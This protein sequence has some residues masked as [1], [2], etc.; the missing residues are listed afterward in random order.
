MKKVFR[1]SL[2]ML[3]FAVIFPIT[4]FLAGCGATPKKEAL[5]VF[6]ESDI[7]DDET[8]YAIFEV[9]EDVVTKLDYKIN[10]STWAGYVITYAVKEC[11]PQNRS[12]FTLDD[13]KIKVEQPEFEEIKIEI[14]VNNHMDTCIVRLKKYPTSMFLVDESGE[15][16]K[17]LDVTINAFGSYTINPYGRFLDANGNSYVQPL[18][19][20]EYGFSLSCSDETVLN[21]PNSSRLKVYSI[22]AAAE[23]AK[24]TVSLKDS[25]GKPLHTV[26]VNIHVVLNAGNAFATI[27]GYDSFVNDSSEIEIDANRLNV[28]EKGNYVLKYDLFIMS[29]DGRYI[30]STLVDN[31]CT[32]SDTKYASVGKE[33]N[34]ILIEDDSLPEIGFKVSIW[35]NLIKDNGSA[36]SISF[37]VKIKF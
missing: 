19:E 34:T 27:D 33:K 21:I 35:T 4:V 2:Y 29:N 12:R 24:V 11:T 9:D 28:D 10:P 3:I 17:T 6:F 1:I 22:R 32:I 14:H 26:E 5:G 15:E 37:D 16:V 23:S 36:Y 8:G 30:D 18:I 7:Y 20:Y 13:G 25:K 31:T